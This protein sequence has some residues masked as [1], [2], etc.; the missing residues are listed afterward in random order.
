LVESPG[1]SKKD[2][3]QLKQEEEKKDVRN[4]KIQLLNQKMKDLEL[5]V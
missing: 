2:Q 5:K 3:A 1:I 4:F